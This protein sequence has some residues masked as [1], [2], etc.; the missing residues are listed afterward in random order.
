[1]FLVESI[2]FEETVNFLIENEPSQEVRK[3]AI[4]KIMLDSR[5][6]TFSSE[7]TKVG[8]NV[9]TFSLPAGWTC[10]FAEE[11]KM[12]V[13]RITKEREYGDKN[14]FECY[15][16]WMEIQYE[17]LRENRW[18]NY[19]LLKEAGSSD[20]Q[21]EL[22]SKSI[23]YHAKKI[24]RKVEM[25]RIH[26]AGDFYNGEYLLAW[27]RVAQ[28]RPDIEFYAYTKSLPYILKYKEQ[29]DAIPNIK[30][31][32]SAGGTHD[33][34][35]AQ[36]G[37]P[38]AS[39][40]MTPEEVLAAGKIVDLDDSIARNKANKEDFALLVHGMQT[41]EIDTPDITKNRLRNEVFMKYH[42]HKH[43]LNNELGLEYDHDISNDEAKVFINDIQELVDNKR[44]T[45]GMGESIQF[46][47]RNVIKYNNYNFD[48]NLIAIVPEKYR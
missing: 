27:L 6:L 11:C 4:E 34:L 5:V 25:V 2:V 24:K 1:M 35:I 9:A 33:E 47:L 32:M 23:D 15:A 39:V 48:K 30:F 22:I 46:Y 45:K 36:T 29:I 20:K 19:D 28:M 3:K 8:E 26:E 44:I 14:K 18:H 31:N 7:N 40:Y 12:K 41:F 13:D 17:S 10:P 43:E 37:Y 21:A 42:K 38:Q 16:A